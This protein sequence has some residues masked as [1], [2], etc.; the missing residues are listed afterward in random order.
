LGLDEQGRR[1]RER[2]EELRDHDL[3]LAVI[4]RGADRRHLVR[5]RVRVRVGVGVAVGV[6]VGFP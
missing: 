1:L 6:A 2:A 4:Q 5:V 3:D